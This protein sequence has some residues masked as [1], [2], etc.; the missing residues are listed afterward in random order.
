MN[1]KDEYKSR[2]YDNTI[3]HVR[4]KKKKVNTRTLNIPKKLET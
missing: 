1:S 3:T 2:E 4:K